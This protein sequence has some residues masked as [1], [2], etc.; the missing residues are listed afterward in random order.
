MVNLLCG[1]P[2]VH[3]V[4]VLREDDR[5]DGVAPAAALV[6]VRGRHRA[7]LKRR[8]SDIF[9]IRVVDPDP[10]LWVGFGSVFEYRSAPGPYFKPQHHQDPPPC[11]L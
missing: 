8:T 5:E 2:A 9:R 7:S 11:L 4:L 1:K 3:V 6:H 10:G